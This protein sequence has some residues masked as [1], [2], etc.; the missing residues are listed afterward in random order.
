MIRSLSPATFGILVVIFAPGCGS[1]GQSRTAGRV[2]SIQELRGSLTKATQQL[3][4]TVA[5]LEG[6]VA[7][8]S[9]DLR[10]AYKKFETQLAT[11]DKDAAT[12]RN[13]AEDMRAKTKE[14]L[15]AWKTEVQTGFSN[16]DLRRLSEERQAAAQAQFEDLKRASQGTKDAYQKLAND[17]HEVKKFL[18]IELNANGVNAAKPM[19]ATTKES[20]KVVKEQVMKLVGELDETVKAISPSQGPPAPGQGTP[21]PATSPQPPPTSPPAPVSPNST[22]KSTP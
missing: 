17:L 9:G 19:V 21:A 7:S 11:L 12:A 18:D 10:P 4:A 14:Y 1:T 20:A 16:P 13:R 8:A 22:P 15:D 2:E 6:V 5:S 3:D